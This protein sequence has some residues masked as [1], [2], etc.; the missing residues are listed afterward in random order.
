MVSMNVTCLP[1][2]AKVRI[3]EALSGFLTDRVLTIALFLTAKVAKWN[4]SEAA[5]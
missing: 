3:S 2:T 1:L 5:S 4:I